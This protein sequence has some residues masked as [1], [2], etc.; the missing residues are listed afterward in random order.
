[1]L[2]FDDRKLEEING[3]NTAAEICQQPETWEKTIKQMKEIEGELSSF[4]KEVTEKPDYEVILTGAGSSEYVGNAL[5]PSLIIPLDGHVRSVGTTDI[6]ASPHVYLPEDK[7]VL[8]VSFA[9][10]GNSPESVGAVTAADTVCKD[11]KHIFITCN[12]DGALA[13]E[14]EK[15]DDVFSIVLAPETHDKGFAMTSSLTNMYLAAHIAFHGLKHLWDEVIANVRDFLEDDYQTLTDFLEGKDFNRIVYLG[16]DSLKGIAQESALKVLE[17]TAG[18]IAAIH[19]TPMGFRHGPKS[20]VDDDTLTVVYIS[21]RKETRK[22]ELDLLAELYRDRKESA[23]I[24]V[25]NTGI[26]DVEGICDLCICMGRG[27]ELDN[28]LLTIEYLSMAQVLAL[29]SSIA[30]GITPDNPCPT[31]E[32][33]R[34]VQGVTIYPVKR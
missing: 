23:V 28:S 2:G 11:V 19:D 31:G 4:I 25:I 6:V 22:Y 14:G 26:D 18:K 20:I 10:S 3:I 12:K 8:L 7:P 1:M 21:D 29:Y 5:Y 30:L 9:R 32:V 17:L 16:T 27:K 15:R 13:V 24:A 33:N 34:V